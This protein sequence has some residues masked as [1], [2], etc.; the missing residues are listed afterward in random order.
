[1][2]TSNERT[3]L[4][5]NEFEW[6]LKSKNVA[7]ATTFFDDDCY[8]RDLM[9]FTWASRQHVTNALYQYINGFYNARRK[10]S[11]IGGLSPIKLE[12]ISA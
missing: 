5:L 11:A 8:W 9:S 7:C 3:A 10:H 2:S 12:I 1:M 6:A 4:W